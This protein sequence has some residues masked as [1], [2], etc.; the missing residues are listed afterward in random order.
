MSM[1]P[2]ANEDECGNELDRVMELLDNAE[3][4]TRL[5]DWE[6]EFCNSLRDRVLQYKERTRISPKQ[7]AIIERIETKLYG[8]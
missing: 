1:L 3:T 4:A 5:S 2:S 8:F 6:Q 7:W